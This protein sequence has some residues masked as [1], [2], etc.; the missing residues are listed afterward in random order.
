MRLLFMSCAVALVLV[1]VGA[2]PQESSANLQKPSLHQ[3][4]R[5]PLTELPL[6]TL[7]TNMQKQSD[8]I[9]YT[10]CITGKTPCTAIGKA[11]QTLVLDQ[12]NSGRL[13]GGCTQCEIDRVKYVM[14][15]LKRDYKPQA[16]QIQTHLQWNGLFGTPDVCS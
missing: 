13:C 5:A 15:V 2:K 3:Q 9:F 11:L 12:R 7:V 14:D 6:L 1:S 4:L 16:C 8:V 10:D